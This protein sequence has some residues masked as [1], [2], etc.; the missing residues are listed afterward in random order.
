MTEC[1]SH[2]T[3]NICPNLHDLQQFRLKKIN[4]IKDYFIVTTKERGLMSKPLSKY[5]AS[6]DYLSH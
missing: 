4:E 1:D 6:F 5:L 2:E 3:P